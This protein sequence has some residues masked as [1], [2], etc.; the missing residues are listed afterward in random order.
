MIELNERQY[1]DMRRS[2]CT[3]RKEVVALASPALLSITKNLLHRLGGS[4]LAVL[5]CLLSLTVASGRIARDISIREFSDGMLDDEGNT[6]VCGTGLSENSIRTAIKS[7]TADGLLYV[8]K[9]VRQGVKDSAARLYEI[10]FNRL[11]QG[12]AVRLKVYSL[13]K[14]AKDPLKNCGTPFKNCRGVHIS[15]YVTHVP[16]EIATSSYILPGSEVARETQRES[17]VPYVGKKPT[18]VTSAPRSDAARQVISAVVGSAREK[19]ESRAAGAAARKPGD[20]TRAE[21][22][23]LFDSVSQGIDLPYRLMVTVREYGYLKKRLVLQAPADFRD[24]VR[25]SLT[26]WGMLSVQNRKAVNSEV[27][28]GAKKK[29]LPEA[30]HFQT[31][32]YWY[33]YFFRVYQNHLAGQ[34]VVEMEKKQ[35]SQAS[36]QV[37]SLERKLVEAERANAVLKKRVTAARQAPEAPHA[38]PRRILPAKVTDEDLMRP[39]EF[40]EW[41]KA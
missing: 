17:P 13:Q 38:A 25:F 19:V 11:D 18:T 8:Y 37:A 1:A 3:R 20:I 36:A 9:E 16:T 24:M 30:P 7:L 29:Y 32:A 41:D 4:E 28:K 15:N 12:L 23:A 33:P 2:R 21:M 6:V 5:M 35:S 10:N 26:Y 27:S 22:Q 40:P 39:T 34:T 14:D 31:F